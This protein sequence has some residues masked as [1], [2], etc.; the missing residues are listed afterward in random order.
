MN[1]DLI[2]GMIIKEKYRILER[3]GSWLWGYRLK[4]QEIDSGEEFWT[5][6]LI[7]PNGLK[8][9]V[10]FKIGDRVELLSGSTGMV[11][12]FD[13][14]GYLLISNGKGKIDKINYRFLKNLG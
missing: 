11:R 8:S 10:Q 13:Q 9:P 6:Q 12:D 7:R 5:K 3:N 1:D 4:V 2:P 14:S